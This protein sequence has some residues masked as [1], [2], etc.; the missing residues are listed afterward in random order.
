MNKTLVTSIGFLLFIIGTI[1][2]I[3]SLVGLQLSILAPLE[4]L[5]G[6]PSFLIKILITMV[7]LILVYVANTS[8][9]Q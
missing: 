5:G 4:N 9:D 7:G 8:T 6:G 3:L 2:I 1:A